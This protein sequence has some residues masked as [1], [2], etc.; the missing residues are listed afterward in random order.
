MFNF[1]I[2]DMLFF[3]SKSDTCNFDDDN[4][5]YFCGKILGH[6]LHILKFDLG[7]ITKQFE[8]NSLKPNPGKFQFMILEINTAIKINLFLDGNNIEKI[9]W[10]VLLGI[11]ID[12]KLSFKTDNEK[13]KKIS[14]S[15]IPI[16]RVIK[17]KKVF[18]YQ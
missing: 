2:N 7:H 13:K 12:D 11:T 4:T 6:I 10:I 9:Q 18:K 16:T 1:F 5:T 15:K 8:M 14:N 17:H 3:V